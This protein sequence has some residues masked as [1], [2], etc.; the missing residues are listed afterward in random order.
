MH[1]IVIVAT[2]NWK[3]SERR[4]FSFSGFFRNYT[5]TLRSNFGGG[6]IQQSESRNVVGGQAAYVQSFRPALS[7][8]AGVDVRRDAPRKLDLNHVDDLGVFQ[9]VT[10]N[11]L[12][13][14]FVEPFVSLDG[15]VS[16]YLHYD[17]GVRQEQVWMDN[18]DIINP[19]NSFNRLATL[20]L[21]KGTLTLLPPDRW[22]LPTLAFSYG[23]AFHTND[24][25]I[26]T[27]TGQPT[28][29]SP[30]R[31]YQLV[32]SKV[33]K[34]TQ[35]YV[36]LRRVSNSQELAKIDADT[37]LQEIVGPSVNKVLTVSIQRTFLTARSTSR[38][39]RPTP[40]TLRRVCP[41]RKHHG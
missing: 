34:Q 10:S 16:R 32:L 27:G 4:Q 8:L 11:N 36:T 35:L 24:P 31:A 2:D 33:V 39:R 41:Y 29:L 7:L 21:P 40:E 37:G 12:T 26:G 19:Q 23:E 9:P 17:L 13:L 3:L 5:L 15:R 1:T 18:Q 20:T 6:L 14:S 38:T 28:L 30:S 25:R 22:Y